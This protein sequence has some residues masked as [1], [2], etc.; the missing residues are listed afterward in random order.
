MPY[1]DA[2]GY[3]MEL[4]T[5]VNQGWFNVLCDLA[6]NATGEPVTPEQLNSIWSV[7]HNPASYTPLVNPDFQMNGAA[8]PNRA[9]PVFLEKI[10]SFNG[11]KKLSDGLQVQLEKQ[12]TLIFGAN[13]SGKS[14]ICQA[15]KV[16]ASPEQP[17]NPLHNARS[18]T[19]PRPSFNFRFRGDTQD[20]AWSEQDG[21]GGAGEYIKYFDST[22][23]LRYINDNIETEASVEISVFR[24]EIFNYARTFLDSFQSFSRQIINE[25]TSRL[26]QRIESLKQRI[27]QT[28]DVE[29]E[30]FASWSPRQTRQMAD[31]INQLEQFDTAKEKELADTE[32]NLAQQIAASSEEGLITLNAQLTLINQLEQKLIQL[33]QY[34]SSTPLAELQQAEVDILQK[35]A[36]QAELSK[37]IFPEGAANAEQRRAL[38][39]S[40]S[41]LTN[42]EMAKANEAECPLCFQK[43]DDNAETVFR[44]YHAFLTSALQSEINSLSS[45]VN[46]AK[47]QLNNIRTFELGNY[48]PCENFFPPNFFNALSTL[49]NTI[50]QSMPIESSPISTGNSGGFSKSGELPIFIQSVSA[51]RQQLEETINKGTEDK[52][53]LDKKIKQLQG[54]IG[55][56]KALQKV[57]INRQEI[58]EICK[59]IQSFIPTENNYNVI[60]FIDISRRM[61]IEGKKAHNE[62]VL[63]T[64]EQQLNSEYVT[65]SGMTLEEMGVKLASQGRQQDVIVTPEIGGNHIQRILSEGE[66]KVHSLATFMCEAVTRPQQVL[67]FDDPVT[68]FDYNYVSNFCERLR[69]LVRNQP[70]TQIIMLTHNWDFFVN[71]QTVLNKSGFNNQLS[72]QV[73]ENCST[74]IEY[75]EKW[76]ELCQQIQTVMSLTGEPSQTEKERLSGLMR[77]L[78]ER[79]TNSFVFNEQRHQYKVK[80]LPVSD[81]QSFTKIVPLQTDEANQLSDLYSRLSPTEHDDIRTFYTTKTKEQYNTWYQEIIA[82]K[83]AVKARRP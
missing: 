61:S 81:F 64:Y 82:I 24:L 6:L 62:L 44:S 32:K 12:I 74:V 52:Q 22:A 29:Q 54:Q 83:D 67:V 55:N 51:V 37:G 65:L 76:D 3:L 23:A 27:I 47:P 18:A 49:T 73:L 69:D 14:S 1:Q 66:Q 75:N 31:W 20:R 40:A 48:Q 45:K 42:Y 70:E 26:N 7:L 36:A 80:S 63:S 19:P 10:D 43:L 60:N 50:I 56:L 77:R 53:A 57:H 46:N 9:Q 39:N 72:V 33:N 30:P 11:F 5:T 15:L 68:S 78:I 41:H 28:V 13:G 16:L 4:R 59:D 71:L 79:L 2:T 25:Q 21:F 35:R 17:N 34:C 38:I 8:Q 58:Q